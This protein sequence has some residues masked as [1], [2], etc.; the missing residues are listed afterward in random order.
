VR[1]IPKHENYFH[2]YGLDNDP[3]PDTGSDQVIYITPELNHRL[4]LIKHLLEFSQ[5]LL[6][7]TAPVDAGKSTL[8]G[9]LP[10]M[11]NDD[12]PSCTLRAASDM[13]PGTL[14][15]AILEQLYPVL[16]GREP[17]AHADLHNYLEYCDHERKL[18]V[19]IIDDGH[20]LPPDTLAF[21]LQWGAL[22]VNNTR[23]RFVVFSAPEINA[24][25]EE[26]GI[27]AAST[28][29]LHNITIPPLTE[30]QVSAYLEHRLLANGQVDPYPFTEQDINYIHKVSGGAPGK[31]NRLARQIMQ[32]PAQMNAQPVILRR[33]QFPI[34]SVVV[35]VLAVAVYYY[36]KE[37]SME[38]Q[39]QSITVTLPPESSTRLSEREPVSLVAG[40]LNNEPV[41]LVEREAVEQSIT[42]T[43]AV[44]RREETQGTAVPAGDKSLTPALVGQDTAP[45]P[46]KAE[47][48]ARLPGAASTSAVSLSNAFAGLQDDNWVRTQAP[49][50]YVL[51]L[52]GAREISTLEQY[53]SRRPGIRARLAVITTVNAGRPW[54]VLLYGLYPDR[55]SAAADIANLPAVVRADRPWPRTVASILADLKK[56]N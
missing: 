25:L 52:I 48:E 45:P 1:N 31:I 7:V 34:M 36:A 46:R 44:L 39:P 37:R 15:A 56:T 42:A 35:V 41:D 53:L 51:Q 47:N 24:V 14:V 3:F 29:I 21:I 23:L 33:L 20:V 2:R 38:R 55:D 5:Q 43:V 32:D 16:Q 40:G 19:I 4:E 18:P 6:L 9:Y 27:K 13:D 12:W 49:G 10:S 22:Q 17:S 54:Y 28:G 30:P 11:F 50:S 8:C 26:P